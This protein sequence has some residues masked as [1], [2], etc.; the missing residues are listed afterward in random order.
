MRTAILLMSQR[1]RAGSSRYAALEVG[2]GKLAMMLLPLRFLLGVR[3]GRSCAEGGCVVKFANVALVRLVSIEV[4]SAYD[5]LR[6]HR[7]EGGPTTPRC[8]ALEKSLA[9]TGGH[10]TTP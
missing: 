5:A 10:Q 3:Y 7:D 1:C 2:A 9:D 8:C 4:L 6:N